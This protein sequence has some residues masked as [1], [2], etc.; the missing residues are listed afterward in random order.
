MDKILIATINMLFLASSITA[1]GGGGGGG[2]GDSAAPP[3]AADEAIGGIWVGTDSSGT[4]IVALSTESGRVHWVSAETG[5]QGF[6]TGSVDGSAVT[7]NY[8]YVAPLGASLSDGS[9]SANCVATGTIQERQSLTVTT[10]CTTDSGGS[11]SNSASMAYDSLYDRDSS[12]A[13]IA[14]NYDDAGL[15]FNIA[16]NGVIFEQDPDTACVLNGQVTIIDPQFNAYD[17]SVT[18]SSCQGEFSI[19]N[20]AA[21]TGLA[22][23]DNTITPEVIVIAQTGTVEGIIVSAVIAMERL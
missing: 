2:S 15:T 14:G 22:T 10:N 23:L 8:T 1:C 13:I 20:G 12:L 19:L 5:E 18:L 6:G 4:E 11:F 16:G 17:M 21:F 9:S 3:P 7:F